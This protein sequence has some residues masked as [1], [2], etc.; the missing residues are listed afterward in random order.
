MGSRYQCAGHREFSVHG[1]QSNL[2]RK[3]VLSSC[4]NKHG[5][6]WFAGADFREQHCPIMA[7]FGAEC[8][9]ANHNQSD[10]REFLDD[11]HE[12]SC[13]PQPAECCYERSIGPDALLSVE[14]AVRPGLKNPGGRLGSVQKQGRRLGGNAKLLK[15]RLSLAGK[16]LG[17]SPVLEISQYANH[18]SCSK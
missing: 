18:K 6:P 10:G 12:C 9:S 1:H 13:R 3:P 7:G 8:Q 5:C 2:R 11:G 15:P 17:F 14:D 16:P 4:E